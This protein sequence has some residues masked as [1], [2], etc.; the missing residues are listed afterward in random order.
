MHTTM[1]TINRKRTKVLCP[2]ALNHI[3]QKRRPEVVFILC[4]SKGIRTPDPLLVRQML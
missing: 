4:G 3:K 1:D 2:A